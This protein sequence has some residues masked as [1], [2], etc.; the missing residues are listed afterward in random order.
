MKTLHTYTALER[1]IIRDAVKEASSRSKAHR[2]R[3]TLPSSSWGN[4]AQRALDDQA[5][6]EHALKVE[7]DAADI[8][9]DVLTAA[10]RRAGARILFLE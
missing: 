6:R 2:E 5:D 3:R 1:Q 7:A 9:I 8:F 4:A 10:L